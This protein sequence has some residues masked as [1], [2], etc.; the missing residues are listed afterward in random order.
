MDKLQ[1]FKFSPSDWM[2]G[3]IQRCDLDTQALFLRLCCIYWNKQCKLSKDDAIFEIN[4][5]YFD[6]LVSKKIIFCND[7]NISISFLDEQFMEINEEK[8]D[9]SKSGII[10]NLKRWHRPIFDS[11]ER[12]EISLEDAIILS[13]NNSNAIAEQSHPDSNAIAEQS[14]IIAEK[15]R[16]DKEKKRKRKEKDINTPVSE[17]SQLELSEIKNSEFF[18]NTCEFFDQTTEVM[19]MRVFGELVRLK[20]EN[21]ILDFQK[22]TEAYISYKSKTDEIV[23]RWQNYI[24][25]WHNEDWIMK[26]KKLNSKSIPKQN[27]QTDPLKRDR[28]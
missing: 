4:Q 21:L 19:Q 2:M 20:R 10:G 3:R 18:K 6:I 7:T 27:P 23:H 28:F 24:Q 5:K 12:K 26:L 14:Q 13:K 9:K 25:E 15:N 17:F 16:E 1:W 11:Y 22:Q 8:Q